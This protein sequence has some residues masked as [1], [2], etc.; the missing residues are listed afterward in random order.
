MQADGREGLEGWR[1]IFIL[2]GVVC[3]IGSRPVGDRLTFTD[4]WRDRHSRINLPG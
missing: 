2:E 3:D 1:W 4:H